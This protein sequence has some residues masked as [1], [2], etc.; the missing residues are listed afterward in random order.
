[1]QGYVNMIEDLTSKFSL[2]DSQIIGEQNKKDFIALF[3]SIL[4]MRNLL[5]S[6]D[7]FKEKELL[8]ERELQDYLGRYQDLR[9]E[10]KRKRE[11]GESI[12]ISNNVVFEV[13]LIKQIEVNI[14]YILMLV[15]RYH[16]AH[17]EDIEILITI[18][19]AIEASQ[20]MRSKKDLI[21]AFINGINDV[22]DVMIEWHDY[23]V[24]M[25]EQ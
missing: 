17:C 23:V 1:M 19:K 5:V 3:G 9:D 22:D 8:T 14:D 12:D 6:F 21:Y 16:D 2:S 20:E 15:K 11:N 7:K 24:E 18:K 25:R 13:E 4:R 10:W